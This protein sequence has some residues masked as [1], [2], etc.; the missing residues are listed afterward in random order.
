MLETTFT[1]HVA[2]LVAFNLCI[3]FTNGKE[4]FGT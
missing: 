4:M 2:C 3:T 1:N